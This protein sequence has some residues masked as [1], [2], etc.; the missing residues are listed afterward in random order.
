MTLIVQLVRILSMVM[1]QLKVTDQWTAAC[2]LAQESF[3]LSCTT[4]VVIIKS[5]YLPG[6]DLSPSQV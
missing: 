2:G 3:T 1:H 6:I 4:K 5:C